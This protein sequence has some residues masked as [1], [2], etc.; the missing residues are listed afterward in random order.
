VNYGCEALI[1]RLPLLLGYAGAQDHDV[2][3]ACRKLFFEAVEMNVA[4]GQYQ[5]RT[6]VVNFPT[7][8]QSFVRS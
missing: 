7:A 4:L 5:R 2:I 6:P 8:R 3:H 1:N